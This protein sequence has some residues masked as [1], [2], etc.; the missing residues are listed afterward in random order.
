MATRSFIAKY[1]RNENEY[2]AIYCHWDGYPEGVGFTL[3]DH[4]TSSGQIDTL[5][6]YG[7]ISSLHED[8]NDTKAVSF[9]VTQG[10]KNAL[11]ITFKYFSDVVEHYRR[12]GCEYGYVW[13]DGLWECYA[14]DPQ[15]IN[16]YV[17]NL[18]TAS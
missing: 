17:E 16:L 10:D 4:Y 6:T 3:R 8:T 12:A 15:Q 5:L 2:T 11:P 13:M 14:L 7:D 1:D 9:Q 18:Q